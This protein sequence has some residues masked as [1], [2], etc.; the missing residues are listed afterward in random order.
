[1]YYQITEYR[2]TNSHYS[3]HSKITIHHGNSKR[4][5]IYVLVLTEESHAKNVLNHFGHDKKSI[6]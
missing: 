2:Y 6:W 5:I 3:I 1:M 4:K